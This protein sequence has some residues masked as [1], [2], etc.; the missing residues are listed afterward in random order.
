MSE[1]TKSNVMIVDDELLNLHVLYNSLKQDYNVITASSGEKALEKAHEE[2][3][4][5]ILL[6]IAMPGMN[7]F[8]VLTK[9]KESSET[10]NIPVIFITGMTSAKDEAKGLFLGAVDYI[11]KPFN[12]DIVQARIRTHL[13]I[14]KQMRLIESLGMI[15][16]LTDLANRRRFDQQLK[17]EWARA[18]REKKCLSLLT[19]DVDK[20]KDYNDAYG[21]P[22]GDAL[23]QTL[24]RIFREQA[25]RATDL[26]AR[27]GGEE[28]VVLLPNSDLVGTLEVGERIRTAVE[29]LGEPSGENPERP[30]TVSLGAATV[31]PNANSQV[32]DF[33][34]E[35]DAKLY[36][37]KKTGRNRLCY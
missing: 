27:I 9:L 16:S 26:V 2:R 13:K 19:I 15:D 37:A 34:K 21:H 6:D 3:L 30:V 12:I 31:F 1:E 36:T 4:D 28:F 32:D 23:L 35:C 5:I 10:R 20:F 8:D 25:H 33:I 29:E 18:I 11:A 24:S 22:M 7:G 17:I 14:I